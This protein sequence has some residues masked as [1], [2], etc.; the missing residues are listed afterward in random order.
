[1]KK[2]AVVLSGCG[3]K[4]G[5]EITESVSTL[6]ALG[7]CQADYQCFAPDKTFESIDHSNGEPSGIRNILSEAARIARGN[8]K[9]LSDLNV[10][11]YEAVIFPGGFGAALHLCSWAKQGANCEVLPDVVR[12]ISEFHSASKPIGAICIAPV[13]VAK[14]LGDQGVT[15]TIGDDSETAQEIEKTGALHETCPVTDYV[16]DRQHKVVTTPAY[17]YDQ[18]KPS[19]VFQ[20]IHGLI[21]EVVEMA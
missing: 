14:I 8:V 12:I 1:M 3:F 7:Q 20:G 16:T 13:L 21:R 18:A 4:D 6:I 15:V 10:K 2:I 5:A 17:M 19:Q 11:N 9:K